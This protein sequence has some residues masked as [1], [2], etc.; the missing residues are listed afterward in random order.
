M[1]NR[2]TH[3]TAGTV[4]GLCL[5]GSLA[6][7]EP[8]SALAVEATGGAVGGALGSLVPDWIE[9]ALHSWHRSF[10]HSYTTASALATATIQWL[11]QW[12]QHCRNIAAS[13]DEARARAT[14][15]G[16]RLWHAF[17]AILWRFVS[18]F[19]AGFP[20]GYLSHLALDG[21]TPR[22]LPLLA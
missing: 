19:V 9:P 21:C 20:A 15:D 4:A 1:A 7:R 22:G 2:S 11:E 17:M 16:M 6:R 3:T 10:A 5:S 8:L 18:G 12:Q 14:S 13:H